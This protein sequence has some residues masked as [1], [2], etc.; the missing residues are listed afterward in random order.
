M[1]DETNLDIHKYKLEIAKTIG[2]ILIPIS[3]FVA[4]AWISNSS[5]KA[6]D[7]RLTQEKLIADDKLKQQQLADDQKV[8]AE[9]MGN[10]LKNFSSEKSQERVIAVRYAETLIENGQVSRVYLSIIDL[11][12]KDSNPYVS[13]AGNTATQN[14]EQ[15][16]ESN[17]TSSTTKQLAKLDK[18]SNLQIFSK[19][20]FRPR[21]FFHIKD[22]TQRDEAKKLA[23]ILESQDYNFLVPGIERVN[24]VPKKTEIRYSHKTDETAAKNLRIFLES[25]GIK[26]V[27]IAYLAGYEDSTSVKA[28]TFEIWISKETFAEKE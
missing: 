28:G 3:I 26:S 4:G 20:T 1:F 27:N 10:L 25:Q 17:P 11:A 2:G 13:A 22:E 15:N 9:L 24:N 7:E 5:K 16:V 21:V 12:K 19:L 8:E 18:T 23:A 14:I 6:D